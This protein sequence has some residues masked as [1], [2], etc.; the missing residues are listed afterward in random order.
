MKDSNIVDL[1][2]ADYIYLPFEESMNVYVKDKEYIYKN[3][4][5]Y[6][7]LFRRNRYR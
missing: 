4:S 1:L 7:K 3:E 2:T 5:N 6:R